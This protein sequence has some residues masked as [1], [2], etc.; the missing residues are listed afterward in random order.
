MDR[1]GIRPDDHSIE[2]Q[3]RDAPVRR[4]IVGLLPDDRL[5]P[6][7]LRRIAYELER[8]DNDFGHQ[9]I[10]PLQR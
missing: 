9:V 8:D 2:R 5:V 1:T 3:H 6:A 7:E 4:D 10:V